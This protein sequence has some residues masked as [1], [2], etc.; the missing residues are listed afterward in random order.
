MADTRDV[1]ELIKQYIDITGLTHYDEK[2]KAWVTTKDGETLQGAKDYAD[3][4]ASNYDAAGTA[5]TKVKELADGQVATN[6]DAIAKLNGEETVEG[7]VKKQIADAKKA[8][9]GKITASKYDDTEL[10]GKVT[11]NTTAI[12]KLNGTGE[13]SVSKAVADAV[14]KIVADAPAAYD[15]LKEIADWISSHQ[16]DA[17]SMNSQIKTNKEGLAALVALVGSLPEGAEQKTIVEY[18]DAKVAGVNFT[19]AIAAAKSE[20]IAAAATDAKAKADKALEDAKAYT[21]GKASDYATAAQGAKA[22]TALQK[23]DV[24]TGTTNG[25]VS[26]K[27]ENVAVKGLASAAYE[28]AT[29]FEKAGAAKALENGQVATNKADILSLRTDVDSLKSVKISAIPNEDIDKLFATE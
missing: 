29:S 14:A 12:D 28:A 9:E 20:A 16:S 4:L 26:V 22:D 18:I 27:G 24:I 15:T 21:D 23:A 1:N 25:T 11:A 13:G 17:T 19:D 6:K 7:S 5:A 8:I 3:G 10:K 2:L